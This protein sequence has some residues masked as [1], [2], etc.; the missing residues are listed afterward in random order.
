VKVWLVRAECGDYYC[1]CG[2]G[3]LV[4]VYSTGFA[5]VEAAAFAETCEDVYSRKPEA[6]RTRRWYSAVV[7]EVV[8]DALPA[9]LEYNA[10]FAR[11]P[12]TG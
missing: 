11:E 10:D 6:R 9:A 3:H 7:E 1:G 4:G 2:G 12:L 8:L 5:A